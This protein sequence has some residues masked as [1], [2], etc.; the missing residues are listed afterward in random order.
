MIWRS[1]N[2]ER[3]DR[4]PTNREWVD[5]NS[6]MYEVAAYPLLFELGTGGWSLNLS[7]G[8]RYPL[9]TT[10][11]QLTILKYRY[12]RIR[13]ILMQNERVELAARAANQRIRVQPHRARQ[14]AVRTAGNLRA[15][16]RALTGC[17]S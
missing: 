7:G 6:A 16:A 4:D 5:Y 9:S 8:P 11:R 13:M 2:P 15:R 12:T 17:T 1:G 14:S 3:E 10:G